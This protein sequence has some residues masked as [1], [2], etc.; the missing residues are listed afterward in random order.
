M[1]FTGEFDAQFLAYC[2]GLK[3]SNFATHGFY[4]TTVSG[5]YHF[6]ENPKQVATFITKYYP[7]TTDQINL[8]QWGD[9]DDV[10]FDR[11]ELIQ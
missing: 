11:T 7:A 1:E 4:V 10:L 6:M 9:G 3:K 2:S 8:A 5:A